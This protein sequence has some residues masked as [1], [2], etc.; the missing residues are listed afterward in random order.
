[1]TTVENRW[2]LVVAAALTVFMAALDVSIVAV[3]LPSIEETFG[4]H[5]TVTEWVALAYLLPLVALSLPSGRWLDQVGKRAAMV[6]LVAGFA[7]TSVLAGAAPWFGWVIGARVAQGAFAAALFALLPVI[8]VL[9]VRPEVRGRAFGVVATVG[10]LGAVTGPALGGFLTDQLGWR[11]IF[12]VNVPVSVVVILIV[13]RT[14]TADGPLRRPD[15]SWGVEALLLGGA[16]AAVLLALSLAPGTG[17]WWAALAVLAVPLLLAWRRL[18]ASR[19]ILELGRTPRLVGAH[20]GLLTFAAAGIGLQYL[21]PFFLRDVT[22]VGPATIGLTVLALPA[23]MIVTGPVA[24]ALADRWGAWRTSLA[25]SAV[26]AAGL[27]LVVP[28]STGWTPVD[29]GWRMAVVGVGAGMTTG[30]IV[31]LAM[32]IAPPHLLATVGASTSLVR[33]LGFALGPALAIGA[34]A[35][36]DYQVAGMRAGAGLAAAAAVLGGLAL[37]GRR[38]GVPSRSHDIEEVAA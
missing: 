9:A 12:Y 6:F 18:P 5:A 22:G 35:A 23:A 13:L 19:P 1:M 30:P 24:G 32:G 20:V 10:P 4:T 34:W 27:A 36:T 17:V 7:I 8:A 26:L 31:T 33:N 11:W 16:T 28:L 3:A 15:R 2:W 38:P 14:M 25:G 37:L 29:I 21:L